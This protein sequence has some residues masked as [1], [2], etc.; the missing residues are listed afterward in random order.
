MLLDIAWRTALIACMLLICL[1]GDLCS[2]GLVA[3]ESEDR[4][5]HRDSSWP[6]VC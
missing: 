4:L 1:L 3:C 5:H 6:N 2:S